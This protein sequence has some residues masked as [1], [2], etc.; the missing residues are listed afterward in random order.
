MKPLLIALVLL[1][2]CSV[3]P[4]MG[5]TFIVQ[6]CFKNVLYIQSLLGTH[7]TLAVDLNGKPIRCD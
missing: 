6:Y 4:H 2:G 1:S 7:L 5:E 3:P